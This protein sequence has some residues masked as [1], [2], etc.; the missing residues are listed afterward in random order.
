[1]GFNFLNIFKDKEETSID[2]FE[3]DNHFL[4]KILKF[5]HNDFK[6]LNVSY[7]SISD[8]DWAPA[9]VRSWDLNITAQIE[10]SLNI[11]HFFPSGEIILADKDYKKSII[12]DCIFSV[13]ISKEGYHNII[14][15]GDHVYVTRGVNNEI[16]KNRM[17]RITNLNS[18]HYINYDN[19]IISTV[20]ISGKNKIRYKKIFIDSRE[21]EYILSEIC[22][23]IKD[24]IINQFREE[25]QQVERLIEIQ[26]K[27]KRFNE[28]INIDVIKDYFCSVM[29]Y[30]DNY[31]FSKD[32]EQNK[33]TLTFNQSVDNNYTNDYTND[34]STS[35]YYPGFTMD[36]TDR[37]SNMLLEL[38]ESIFRFN[39]NFS[40]I[41]NTNLHIINNQ[42][43]LTFGLK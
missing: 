2:K 38:S 40:Y 30:S 12:K 8:M 20:P 14:D 22:S 17:G 5:E 6:I 15:L 4:S 7:S 34:Y 24:S 31:E 35:G 10:L 32:L 1:M 13:M 28:V 41:C 37:N 42:I 43:K 9:S 16:Y 39:Q 23:L 19:Q 33:Y 29:D 11:N 21:I 3:Y 26:N 25:I 27:I 18:N 36:I